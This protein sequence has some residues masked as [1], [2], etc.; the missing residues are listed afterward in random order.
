MV[1]Q[2]QGTHYG[3]LSPVSARY[4]VML[5]AVCFEL[6]KPYYNINNRFFLSDALQAVFLNTR[7]YVDIVS[8]AMC[9]PTQ[10]PK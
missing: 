10:Q 7:V 3:R 9:L 2:L 6:Y 4:T 1:L 5:H 8:T